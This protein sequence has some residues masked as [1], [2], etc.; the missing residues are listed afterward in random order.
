MHFV[1][2]LIAIAAMSAV[3]VTQARQIGVIEPAH[4]LTV[5][6][7]AALAPELHQAWMDYLGRSQ[8]YHQAD[9]AALAAERASGGAIPPLPEGGKSEYS[10]PLDKPAMWYSSADALLVANNIV[11]FQ[12]P[13]GG[14]GK[15]QPRDRPA[16]VK[17]QSFV[18]SNRSKFLAPGDFD[19]P[20]DES[21]SYVGTIDNDATITEIR[22]LARVI[23]ALPMA[24]S[25]T[26]RD[27][28]IKGVEYLLA[29]Q[30]PNGGWPQVWPLQGGYH[31]AITINDNAMVGVAELLGAVAAGREDFTFMP[32]GL[33]ERAKA[34]ENRAI[35]GLLATQVVVNGRKG[36]WA[37]QHDALTLAPTSARN[38]E[39]AALCAAESASVLIYLMTLPEPSPDVV[40]AIEGG[41]A[42][43]RALAIEG[44]AW[45]KVS[46]QEGRLLVPQPG[47]PTLWARYYDV[48]TLKPVFGDR[49]KSLHDNV[50]DLSL[51]RRN[52]YAWYGTGPS[53]ALEKYAV[54][55]Q[56]RLS[57]NR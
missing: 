31:D 46:E 5:Q 17:G 41:I 56:R 43:L 36:L 8:R 9:K 22:F 25:S 15:N 19:T 38:Y 21:W 34:A 13:A 49:D 26:Y 45:R 16:R 2:P 52:G 7:A 10:M 1:T 18:T 29:A 35:A 47:A 20:E 44:K 53:K 33:R 50:A 51:E 4:A 55:K 6:R 14:W 30:F 12:T 42:V 24:Q 40:A 11:S 3:A 23:S 57:P 37:Q 39:P 48:A 32:G 28:A 27:S 54:W